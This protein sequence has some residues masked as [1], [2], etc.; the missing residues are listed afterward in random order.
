[1][2][3]PTVHPVQ[4]SHGGGVFDAF[5]TKLNPGGSAL[6]YSTYLG[7]SGDDGGLGIAVD[8]RGS[9]YVT[10]G[11]SS[12]D[13]P[14]ASPLQGFHTASGDD[15]FVAK[16]GDDTG[17]TPPV[18]TVPGATMI[19][20]T[21]PDG[22]AFSF[23]ALATDPDDDAG[24]V[25]CT[26][27]SGSQFPLGMTTVTC[28]STDTHGNTG[29]ASFTLTVRDTTPPIVHRVTPSQTHLWPPNHR[30]ALIRLTVDAADL[31][32][33][34]PIC[35]ITKVSSNEP[36]PRQWTITGPLSVYL[37]AS[38][39]GQGHGRIYTI[40]VGCADDAGNVSSPATTTVK[41]AHSIMGLHSIAP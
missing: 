11:T 27:P 14:T 30:R 36:G 31:V 33:A 4:G 23:S 19:E 34:R 17:D 22:A 16:I 41:V 32:T 5:V 18:I 35:R 39:H 20:A 25:T 29:Q 6:L 7:G 8:S 21:G 28:S 38:R 15:A 1:M 24:P 26:P 12:T 40:T 13:F 2:N 37:V 3:F 10:G 9:A